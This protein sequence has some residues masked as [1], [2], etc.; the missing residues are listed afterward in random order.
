MF[1]AAM[2]NEL[3]TIQKMISREIDDDSADSLNSSMIEDERNACVSRPN[4]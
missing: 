1:H 2:I 4:L 3:D